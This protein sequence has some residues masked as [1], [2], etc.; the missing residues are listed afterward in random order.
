MVDGAPF[1]LFM[2]PLNTWP[3]KLLMAAGIASMLGGP[4][5]LLAIDC[6]LPVGALSNVLVQSRSRRL[7]TERSLYCVALRRLLS[8]L[9][10]NLIEE[11]YY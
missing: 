6:I 7:L 8:S 5:I 10:P 9:H 1:P 11:Y 4:L 2:T 3:L